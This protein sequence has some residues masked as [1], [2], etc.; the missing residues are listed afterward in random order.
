MT[1]FITITQDLEHEWLKK[2]SRAWPSLLEYLLDQEHGES[3]ERLQLVS[4]NLELDAPNLP[5]TSIKRTKIAHDNFLELESTLSLDENKSI[6]IS[7]NYFIRG[8]RKYFKMSPEQSFL[9]DIVA[10][11]KISAL[12]IKDFFTKLGTANNFF[13]DADLAELNGHP[14]IIIPSEAIIA[15]LLHYCLTLWPN[16][17]NSLTS[18]NLNFYSALLV[19]QELNLGQE[20]DNQA[21]KLVLYAQENVA[22]VLQAGCLAK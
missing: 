7:I 12:K 18:F 1:K 8:A 22:V 11:E 9:G 14:Q 5:S 2:I 17:K 13:Y 20:L 19:N 15:W 10:V 21:L 3:L 16:T 4:I 6:K